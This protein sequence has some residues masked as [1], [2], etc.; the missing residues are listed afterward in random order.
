MDE[1]VENGYALHPA[2]ATTDATKKKLLAKR[3]TDLTTA[4]HGWIDTRITDIKEAD[5]PESEVE[6][7]SILGGRE[8]IALDCEFCKTDDGEYALTRVSLVNWEGSTILDELVKPERPIVDYVTLYSGITE[9]MLVGVTTTL[10][11]IQK[12][13][14]EIITPRTILMGHSLESDFNALKLTHPFIV[15][16]AL[17]FPARGT[18]KQALRFLT[19]RFLGREIQNRGAKGHDSTEDAIAVLDL[20]KQ[21]CERGPLWGSS[22]GNSEPIFKRLKRTVRSNTTKG[23]TDEAATYRTGAMLD[24]GHPHLGPGVAANKIVACQSDE[25]V[26]EGVKSIIAAEESSDEHMDFIFGRLR[27]LEA[28]RGWWPST[29][30]G[31]S[32]DELRESVL[33]KYSVPDPELDSAAPNVVDLAAAVTRTADHVAAIYASLPAN[34]LF[35]VYTGHGDAREVARLNALETQFRREYATKKWSELTVRWTDAEVQ[36][37]RKAVRRA[38]MGAGFIVVKQ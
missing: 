6:A 35:I 12:R 16:T 36:A 9:K 17:L 28:I 2:M 29:K 11:D 33:K 24:W 38:R 7:G 10:A 30:T 18:Q 4:E 20:V 23:A 37:R 19:K 25:D 3:Q 8:I 13:L 1:L 31:N 14:L 21:K 26:V 34:T 5:V 32:L 27:E 15:D 22:D